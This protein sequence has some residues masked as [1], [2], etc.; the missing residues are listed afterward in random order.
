MK[1]EFPTKIIITAPTKIHAVDILML[2]QY[3]N[4]TIANKVYTEFGLGI[5]F[6]INQPAAYNYMYEDDGLDPDIPGPDPRQFM[7]KSSHL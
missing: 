4:G 1:I 2:E 7:P 5:R 6:H 3:L